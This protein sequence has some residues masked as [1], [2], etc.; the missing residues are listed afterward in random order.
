MKPIFEQLKLHEAKYN[1]DVGSGKHGLLH[2]IIFINCSY[3]ELPMQVW[4]T[5]R[6]IRSWLFRL[7]DRACVYYRNPFYY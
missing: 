2:A 1:F 3:E 7:T 6:I 4:M 5:V